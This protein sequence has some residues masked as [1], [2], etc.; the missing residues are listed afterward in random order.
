MSLTL[1]HSEWPKLHRALA[2][3][4]A[5]GLNSQCD[6]NKTL[7]FSSLDIGVCC[8]GILRVKPFSMSKINRVII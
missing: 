3:L 6:M 1:L 4:S 5:T 8:F 2:L 7:F